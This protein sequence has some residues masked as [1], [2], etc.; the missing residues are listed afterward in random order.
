MGS[1]VVAGK[2]QTSELLN[3]ETRN[4]NPELRNLRTAEQNPGTK[5][6]GTEEPLSIQFRN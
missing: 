2:D 6:P 1:K 3:L 5:E 4:Q